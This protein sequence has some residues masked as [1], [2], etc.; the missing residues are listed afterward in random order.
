MI[1]LAFVIAVATATLL[2][3]VVAVVSLARQMRR[4]VASIAHFQ[5]E[6]EPILRE[7]Q[8]DADRATR[9]LV[10]LQQEGMTAAPSDGRRVV[11]VD[12]D[13]PSLPG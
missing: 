8:T 7:I 3:L 11:S 10:R 12:P 6:L 4:V 5:Q 1:P 13:A 2:V 9:R